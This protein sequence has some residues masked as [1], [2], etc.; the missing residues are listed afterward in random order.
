MKICDVTQFFSPLGGGVRRYI[1][2]KRRYVQQYTQDEHIL[3]IPASDTEVIREGRL[4]LCMVASPR[5]SN[6][7]KYRMLFDLRQAAEFIRE[8]KPDLIECSDPYHLAWKTLQMGRELNIPVLG[9]YHSHFPEAYLRTAMKFG[10]V[11]LRNKMMSLARKYVVNLYNRFDFTLVPSPS[12]AE[13][14]EG[15][16]LENTMPVK[17]GIDTEIFFPGKPATLSREKLNI[18][19]DAFLLLYIGRL[20]GE[21]NTRLLIDTFRLLEEEAPGKF[22][23]LV[24]GDGQLRNLVIKSRRKLPLLRWVPYC[25]ES[26]DLADY[27]RLAD[28]FIHPGVH[29]TFGLVSL[30]SQACGC[31][32]VGI[33]GSYMDAHI[34][35]GHSLWAKANTA[36]AL[37][38][39]VLRYT[40]EDVRALGLQAAEVVRKEYAWKIV[41]EQI[42]GAYQ[43]A[44]DFH[45]KKSL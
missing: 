45:P 42:W 19:P 11:W 13:L 23:F 4:T 9:F 31:P 28:L 27:Y 37:C 6:K 3:L 18:P 12:L 10:G 17:L 5:V 21:K 1:T 29:E 7:T 44:L 22:A 26:K 32:V 33:S 36:Q 16:G 2:E 38:N 14:L 35:A 20:A 39:A 24:I 40:K 34:Y 25:R 8:E 30:E 43:R 41:F 15:W